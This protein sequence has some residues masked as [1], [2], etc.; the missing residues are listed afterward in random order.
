M[1]LMFYTVSEGRVHQELWDEGKAIPDHPIWLDLF[2]PT[3]EEEHAVEAHLGMDIPTREE[4][5]EIEISNRLYQQNGHL[6]MTATLLTRFDSNEPENEAVTFIL[7]EKRLIT[8]RYTDPLPFRSFPALLLKSE[9][10][11]HACDLFAGLLEAIINRAA[12]ILEII[13][14][15]T[16][17]ITK[18]IFVTP[19]QDCPPPNYQE[20]L[21]RI[22]LDGDIAAKARES[23][24]TLWRLTAYAHQNGKCLTP[25]MDAQ[26]D[27][28]TKD[29]SALID[30]ATFLSSKLTFLLDA[31]LGMISIDQNNIIKIFSIAAVI[32][33]PPTLVASVYGMNFHYMPELNWKFGYP[34]ALGFMV[35]AAVLPLWYF[36]RKK[37]L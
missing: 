37:W 36:R 13:A 24:T 7:C 15:K 28:H 10:M 5:G 4:M 31:T 21:I 25:E 6:F 23:L 29:I 3:P 30:H 26:M 8:V 27:A 34:M 2:C 11:T 32:F 1:T 12:D 22:G 35:T 33:L 18:R 17:A 20:A 14:G 9:S 16:D 19:S